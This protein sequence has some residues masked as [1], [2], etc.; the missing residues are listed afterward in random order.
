MVALSGIPMR[1]WPVILDSKPNYLHERDPRASLLTAP[2]GVQS[3][4][5]YLLSALAPITEN[6]PVVIAPDLTDDEYDQWIRQI[7][8]SAQVVRR[9]AAFSA[10]LAKAELSDA[11]LYVDPRWTAVDTAQLTHLTREHYVEP[12]VSHH[13][14]VFEKKSNW[15][16]FTNGYKRL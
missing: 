16:G 7:S 4:L 5:E 12:R 9:P 14:V 10:A 15:Q 3:V 13:L 6:S 1:I 11:L 8:P 2:L